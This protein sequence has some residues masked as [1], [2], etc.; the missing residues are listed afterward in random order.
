MKHIDKIKNIAK[1]DDAQLLT[2]LEVEALNL[3]YRLSQRNKI[4]VASNSTSDE[5]KKAQ[6]QLEHQIEV[7]K[8]YKTEI[9][10]RMKK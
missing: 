2:D 1:L 6:I 7:S 5:I 9:L 10:K 8:A 4:L 3:D